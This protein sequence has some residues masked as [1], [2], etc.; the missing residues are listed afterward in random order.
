MAFVSGCQNIPVE[1][2]TSAQSREV[3][4][5]YYSGQMPDEPFPHLVY[6][7]N[8]DVMA[9]FHD[10][11][12]DNTSY[13]LYQEKRNENQMVLIIGK[14]YV[15]F[16]PL[17][18]EKDNVLSPVGLLSDKD[19]FDFLYIGAIDE[20]SGSFELTESIPLYLSET[21][22]KASN[23]YG[24]EFFRIIVRNFYKKVFE[25]KEKGEAMD[26]VL[27]SWLPVGSM[28]SNFFTL[29]YV[30][31]SIAAYDFAGE[32]LRN[33]IENNSLGIISDS[34]QGTVVDVVVKKWVQ[35]KG[36]KQMIGYALKRFKEG[37]GISIS[38]KEAEER[39]D[40][41]T[42][43]FPRMKRLSSAI[44]QVQTQDFEN[45]YTIDLN[46][47][48]TGE[49]FATLAAKVHT[50][51]SES[52]KGYHTIISRNYE[53][54]RVRDGQKTVIKVDDFNEKMLTLEKAT[55]Y[56]VRASV[57]TLSAKTYSSSYVS[58][59]TKGVMLELSTNE[60]DFGLDG[61]EKTVG[62]VVGDVHTL[63]IIGQQPSW[64]KVSYSQSE[65]TVSVSA[66]N[67]EVDCEIELEA[68][69]QFGEKKN[70]I[71]TVRRSKAL[72]WEG[73][74]WIFKWPS[75][76]NARMT[77]DY[78]WDIYI[79]NVNKGIYWSNAETKYLNSVSAAGTPPITTPSQIYELNEGENNTLILTSH[80]KF[81]FLGTIIEFSWKHTIRRI[82]YDHA[83]MN[84]TYFQKQDG[85]IIEEAN[86]T[87]SGE[88]Q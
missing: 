31:F 76:A 82:D 46:V 84:W 64:C 28:I 80:D 51:P 5:A 54:I 60:L 44:N 16:A 86:Y 43:F 59:C 36:A 6:E 3:M 12:D 33:E 37:L 23:N 41:L 20:L 83:S 27:P 11:E 45:P 61:G 49:V 25:V 88:R 4:L 50:N 68:T 58:F 17:Q 8:G 39:L 79:E 71:L 67:S 77:W 70:T 26:F 2:D 57:R 65:I 9:L 13:Y 78:N 32:E 53:I 55:N 15:A 74:S 69:N 63:K 21:P 72:S 81:S 19:N 85:K 52:G 38:D 40:E 14:D 10:P 18:S 87:L 35:V 48:N 42:A 56:V 75:N 22:T 73:T 47:I 62:V 66:G 7:C 30:F 24:D 29:D 1:E 34:V